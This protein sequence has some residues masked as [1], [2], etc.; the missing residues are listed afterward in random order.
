[1]AG[2]DL[3]FFFSQGNVRVL[4]TVE[5]AS[6]GVR[7]VGGSWGDRRSSRV[8]EATGAFPLLSHNP[9][10]PLPLPSGLSGYAISMLRSQACHSSLCRM[11]HLS[12]A[13]VHFLYLPERREW[14]RSGAF[15]WCWEWMWDKEADRAWT[16]GQE[17]LQWYW[18]EVY[19]EGRDSAQSRFPLLGRSRDGRLLPSAAV[20][21]LCLH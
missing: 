15:A 8:V 16:G 21:R 13:P 10:P 9:C 11:C 17:G 1:M 18:E 20:K 7:M 19:S 14:G 2:K 6:G 5:D 3:F 4:W 12:A